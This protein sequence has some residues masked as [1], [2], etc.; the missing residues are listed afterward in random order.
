MDQL[1]IALDVDS[2]ARAMALTDQLRDVAGGFKIGSRLFTA[3]G[4]AI[5]RRVAESGARVFLDLKYHDI[6]NTVAGAVRA[7]ADL[8]VWMLTVH[9]A[10]GA[11]MLR[12]AKEAADAGPRIV[13]VTVLT[14]LDEAA[15]RR[16]GISRGVADHVDELAGLAQEA[17]IDGVVA[18][19]LEIE[20]IRGRC[21]GTFTVVTPGIR[22]PSGDAPDDQRRTLSAA[23]AIRAG[24]DYLVVGR[25]IIAAPDPRAAAAQIAKQI[26]QA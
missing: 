1:L 7:A 6:P 18:S 9:T 17:G 2:A 5:V 22:N 20:R 10:G 26:T 23:D 4:P 13:G 15:L 11:D 25:P 12:A 3:E 24:A 8:G 19:P 21:G 16:L 14:S